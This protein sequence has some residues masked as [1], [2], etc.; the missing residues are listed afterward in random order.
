MKPGD[1]VKMRDYGNIRHRIAIIV[2]KDERFSAVK[3]RY[4]DNLEPASSTT[5]HL[6]IVSE[7]T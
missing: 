1:L 5:E 2:E 4:V 6:E 7:T 3:M